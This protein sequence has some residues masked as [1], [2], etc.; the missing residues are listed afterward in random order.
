MFHLSFPSLDFS[1]LFLI[2]HTPSPALTQSHSVS[3]SHCL[4]P[5]FSARLISDIFVFIHIHLYC[6]HVPRIT[7]SPSPLPYFFTHHVL[8]TGLPDLPLSSGQA[9]EHVLFKMNTH[10]C[11]GGMGQHLVNG[12]TKW[13]LN[14]LKRPLG[15]QTRPF[16]LRRKIYKDSLNRN[17][18]VVWVPPSFFH[19]SLPTTWPARHTSRLWLHMGT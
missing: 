8:G 2:P 15:K 6:P 10:E 4:T 11:F 9:W 13:C 18:V 12:N 7:R 19:T 5:L 17:V 16:Q 14:G 1:C 3:V